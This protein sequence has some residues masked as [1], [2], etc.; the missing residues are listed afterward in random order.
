MP[1]DSPNPGEGKDS[2]QPIKQL[3]LQVT[4]VAYLS[5]SSYHSLCA[6]PFFIIPANFALTDDGLQRDEHS[7]NSSAAVKYFSE[8]GISANLGNSTNEALFNSVI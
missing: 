3:G 6:A 5:C 8:R 1:N 4:K 7:Q 2:N